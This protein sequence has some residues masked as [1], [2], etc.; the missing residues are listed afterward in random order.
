[1]SG[2]VQPVVG[3][4]SSLSWRPRRARSEGSAPPLAHLG[5]PLPGGVPREVVIR[6]PEPARSALTMVLNLETVLLSVNQKSTIW[7]GLLRALSNSLNERRRSPIRKVETGPRSSVTLASP[8]P[9]HLPPALSPPTRSEEHT[10][11]L[12]SRGH[13]ACRL[14]LEKTQC[15]VSVSSL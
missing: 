11:E 14:L 10:S 15:T 13:L 7:H 1:M 2:P 4:T 6:R 3:L 12:Q 8:A 9:V 5:Q